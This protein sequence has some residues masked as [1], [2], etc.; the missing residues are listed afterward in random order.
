MPQVTPLRQQRTNCSDCRLATLCL[1]ENLDDVAVNDLDGIIKRP[2]PLDR[3]APLFHSGGDF[4]AIYAIR[5]GAVKTS[6]LLPN[7]DEFVSGFYLPGE[8]IGL[9][10]INY[11]NHPTTAVALETTSV[12]EVP[13]SDLEKLSLNRPALQRHMMRI[14]SR[15]LAT[16]QT[17]NQ[18]LVHRSAE[19]R[20]AVVLVS[21]SDRFG[22][23]GLS[24]KRFRLPMSRHELGNYLGLAPET[25]SRIFRR[26]EK[27]ELVCTDGR[28]ITLLNQTEL[29]LLAHGESEVPLRSGRA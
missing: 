28:D 17:L 5:T 10:A 13:F 8:V 15:E 16:E 22:N 29:R 18:V 2:R 24:P 3:G 25:M 27:Q 12:C 20:L 26:L 19:Q 23:R 6:R 4:R 1:P 14:M 11:N 21:L 9:D 7:G